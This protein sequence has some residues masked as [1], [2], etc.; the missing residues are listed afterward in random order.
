MDQF[1]PTKVKSPI[2]GKNNCFE[3]SQT[4]DT[5]E[6]IKSWMCMDSGY[7]S[8]TLNVEGS[9][10]LENYQETTAELIK[11]LKWIDPETKLVW[12]PMVLNFPSFGI[13]FPDGTSKDDWHWM[14]APSVDVSPEEQ[15]KYPIPGQPGQFYTRRVDM[16]AGRKFAPDQFYEAAKFLG[17]VQP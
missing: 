8:T 14:A 11:D 15:K 12:Y 10:I 9:E 17:F 5:G 7:T 4:M 3:H 16:E 6:V 2:S 1:E 13:L